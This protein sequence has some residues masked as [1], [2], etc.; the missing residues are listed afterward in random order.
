MYFLGG[1]QL[2]FLGVIGGYVSKI[3][4]ET[5]QRPRFIIERVL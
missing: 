1:V 5:K 2:L 4:A 3:Y